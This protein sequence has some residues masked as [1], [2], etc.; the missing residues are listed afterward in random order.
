MAIYSISILILQ[1]TCSFVKNGWV[2]VGCESDEFTEGI[3]DWLVEVLNGIVV[4]LLW[5]GAGSKGGEVVGNSGHLENFLEKGLTH[6]GEAA[7]LGGA[8]L[9][10]V[11]GGIVEIAVLDEEIDK[12]LGGDCEVGE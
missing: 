8:P 3:T 4:G 7:V 12:F 5:L 6:S 10:Q 2:K 11:E 1:L 9:E